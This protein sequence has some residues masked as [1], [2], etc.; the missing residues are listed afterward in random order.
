M[1]GVR[2]VLLAA[3]MLGR[4]SA[5]DGVAFFE[6]KIRPIF[7]GK[8]YKCHSA[9]AKVVK[10]ALKLDTRGDFLKDGSDGVVVVAGAPDKS[11]LINA[12]RYEDEGK[13]VAF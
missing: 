3:V 11:A 7:V 2:F 6:N 13:K 9:E 5:D 1:T 10:G 12:V 4:A 8:C